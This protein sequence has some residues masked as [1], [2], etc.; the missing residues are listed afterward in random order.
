MGEG[1]HTTLPDSCWLAL[2]GHPAGR[3]LHGFETLKTTRPQSRLRHQNLLQG[4]SR[5]DQ[6]GTCEKEKSSSSRC[7]PHPNPHS[8]PHPLGKRREAARFHTLR[9]QST[10]LQ[11]FPG[12]VEKSG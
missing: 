4:C 12:K 8:P 9:P 10:L 6:E 1:A 2:I 3:A 7:S 11:K 5:G